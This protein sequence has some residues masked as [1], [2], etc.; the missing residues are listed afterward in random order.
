MS[1]RKMIFLLA[2]RTGMNLIAHGAA[3]AAVPK[4]APL[5]FIA[6]RKAVGKQLPPDRVLA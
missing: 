4:L 2:F 5:L 1:S 3:R 6:T